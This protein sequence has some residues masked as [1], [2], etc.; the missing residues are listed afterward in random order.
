MQSED[1][2]FD[3]EG[4]P[5]DSFDLVESEAV[6]DYEAKMSYVE[7]LIGSGELTAAE[8]ADTIKAQQ[9]EL[10][11]LRKENLLLKSKIVKAHSQG[12]QV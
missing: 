7:D 5:I 11:Q 12:F 4:L 1:L 2:N 10:T 3:D 9:Y 6:E 8:L